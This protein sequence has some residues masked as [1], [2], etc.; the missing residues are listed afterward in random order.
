MW[1]LLGERPAPRRAARHDHPR[2]RPVWESNHV[3]LIFAIVAALH[4]LSARVRRHR[5]RLNAPLTLALI[6]IVLRGAAFVFRNYASD[7]PALART[8]DGR[9]RRVVDHRAV[10]FGDAVGALATGRYAWTSPFALAVGAVRGRAVRADRGGL[11]LR[12]T[13]PAR[14]ATTS[15]AARSAPRSPSGCGLVPALLAHT[16]SRRS[17]PRSPARRRASRSRVAM[18]LGIV[19]MLLRRARAG[20]PRPRRGRRRSARGAGAAGS[21]RRR[22][23]SS[24]PLDAR[25]AAASPA[26]LNAFLIAAGGRGRPHPVAAAAVRRLQRP[27]PNASPS[28]VG[29][30]V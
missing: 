21:A 17:S 12:E 16:S 18:L 27:A 8:L 2:H 20:T 3:W 10:L 7:T 4:V 9:V 15:A 5:D 19:V 6:G 14:C 29:F 13:P 23:R 26:M 22:P 25:T 30:D 1:D 28:D 11:P 24:R